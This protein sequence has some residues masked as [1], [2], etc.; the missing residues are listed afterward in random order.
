MISSGEPDA[1]VLP[2]LF[3][4]SRLTTATAAGKM[5]G[6]SM[7]KE[8]YESEAMQKYMQAPGS[9]PVTMD[10]AALSE[11]MG[12]DWTFVSEDGTF[13]AFATIGGNV[14]HK[15][16][17]D[18]LV[19]DLVSAYVGTMDELWEAMSWAQLG[20][21]SDPVGLLNAFGFY[22]DLIKFNAKMAEVGF[23]RE[24]H[25]NILI[26]EDTLPKLLDKMESYVPHTPIFKM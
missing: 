19:Y 26:A 4:G 22:D 15:D 10:I 5:T 25:Q 7:P 3:P 14:V 21:H 13:R 23:V 6:W 18:Q 17:D 12:E 1:I 16:M 11:T 9:A 24:A 8:A 2:E 20:Y